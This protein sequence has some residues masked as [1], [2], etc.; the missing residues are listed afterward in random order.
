MHNWIISST[1]QTIVLIFIGLTSVD[2]FAQSKI[3]YPVLSYYTHV[4]K[5]VN[6]YAAMDS[7]P[8]RNPAWVQELN[9]AIQTNGKKD[10]H[11]AWGLPQIG[12]AL[13]V[14]NWGNDRQIGNGYGIVP[15][16]TFSKNRAKY[17]LR[18]TLGLGLSYFPVMYDSI[19]NPYD[20]LIGSHITNMSYFRADFGFKLSDNLMFTLGAGSFH[21]SNGH[22]QVPNLGLNAPVGNIGIV[23]TPK[24]RPEWTKQKQRLDIN[25]KSRF[26]VS[27][28]IGVHEF[29]ETTGPVGGP[30]YPMATITVAWAKRA[31]NRSLVSVGLNA[32][33]YSNFHEY[34]KDK[35]Y[36][37]SHHIWNASTINVFLGHEF[38]MN[39][40]SL[41]TNGGIVLHNPF[42]LK[43]YET[44]EKNFFNFVETY[45]CTKLGVRHYF[46]DVK[47][48]KSNFFIGTFVHA[49]FGTAD[50]IEMEFGLVF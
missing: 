6:N 8:K 42:Y 49:K 47:M 3:D 33:Y 23:F 40:F 50:F 46:G 19:T 29:A 35:D 25:R 14:G 17:S 7:F 39:R 43:Y 5:A 11:K 26:L 38:V 9:F 4:G 22:Y 27:S 45:I 13:V 2:S 36:F 21:C 32:K 18:L 12:I 10:W 16:I 28:G 41:L 15:N 31:A 34:I 48:Q 24:S 30:K 1:I 20:I 44:R 37:A